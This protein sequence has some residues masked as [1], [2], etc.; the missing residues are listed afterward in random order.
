MWTNFHKRSSTPQNVRPLSIIVCCYHLPA[1]AVIK[2]IQKIIRPSDYAIRGFAVSANHSYEL[3]LGGGWTS[4]PCQN[5]DFD[6]SAYFAG[7][8]TITKHHSTD[9][10]ILFL[11]DTLFTD[12]SATANLR[13]VLRQLDLISQLKLPAVSG[14]ADHYT[15]VCLCSPWNSLPVYITTFCFILNSAALP[16]FLKLRELAADDKVTHETS[17][18]SVEWGSTLPSSFREFI[19]SMLLYQGSHYLWRRL[20]QNEYSAGQLASKARCIYFEHRLSGIIGELGCILP[21]NAGPRWATYLAVSEF[22]ARFRRKLRL[23]L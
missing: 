4:L 9:A 10:P 5:L 23:F 13:A 1:R 7:V 22:I 16:V 11:N 15:T 8:E 20:R 17:L 6:F 21:S 14:K 19:R 12:H 18:D 2:K 3:D